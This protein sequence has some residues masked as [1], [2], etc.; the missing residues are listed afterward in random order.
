MLFLAQVHS[1]GTLPE[2]EMEQ[3]QL[4]ETLPTNLTYSNV[5]PLLIEEAAKHICEMETI[6]SK[7]II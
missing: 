1:L 7:I 3:A 2:S 5:T 4:F 6:E